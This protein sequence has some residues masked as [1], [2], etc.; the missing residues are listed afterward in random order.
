ML[1]NASDGR[2]PVYIYTLPVLIFG[3]L[4]VATTSSVPGLLIWRFL[5]AFGASPGYV[6]GAGVIGDIYRLEERGRAMGIFFAVILL[7]NTLPISMLT[8]DDRS[9]CWAPQL[10]LLRVVLRRTISP[11]GLCR[12]VSVSWGSLHGSQ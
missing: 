8:E 12:A 3:S 7:Q 11:G 10:H 4:G 2:R 5:Q 6:V 9:Y 1:I